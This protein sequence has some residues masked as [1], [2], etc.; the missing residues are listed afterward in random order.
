MPIGKCALCLKTRELC[1][2]HLLPAAFYR[3]LDDNEVVVVD[4]DKTA[5]L[6]SAQARAHLLCSDCEARFNRG[7]EDWVLKNC[8]RS[9]KRFLLHSALATAIPFSDKNGARVYK[10]RQISGIDIEKL[11]YFG[12]SV[13]WRASVCNPHFGRVKRQHQLR[14]GPYQDPLRLYLLGTTRMPKDM[15]LCVAISAYADELQNTIIAMP[16]LS[17]KQRYHIYQ[18]AVP[19]IRFHMLCG[20]MVPEQFKSHCCSARLGYLYVNERIEDGILK[21]VRVMVEQAE[22]K[23]K[24]RSMK[25]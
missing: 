17:S 12:L 13:F 15:V 10:G 9:P 4:K 2:S 21:T 5:V 7:G 1:D 3:I 20:R 23:G 24:L 11:T 8:W 14:L 25:S 18:F 16:Y 22:P 19:G 6:T